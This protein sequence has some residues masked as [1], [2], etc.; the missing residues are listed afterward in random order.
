MKDSKNDLIIRYNHFCED[1]DYEKFLKRE[2]M[3]DGGIANKIHFSC[4]TP[5]RCIP[6]FEI[7]KKNIKIS[8]QCGYYNNTEFEFKNVILKFV[9]T[10]TP[11]I[12][13]DDYYRC[14]NEDHKNKKFKYYCKKCHQHLCKICLKRT[15][16]HSNHSLVIFDLEKNKIKN[17]A[18][19]INKKINELNDIDK[20]LKILFN[21]IYDNF[22][23]YPL[24]YSYICIFNE[25][26]RFLKDTF[27]LN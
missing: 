14:Q 24:N 12:N 11:F 22:Q 13:L 20:D 8:C 23:S 15:H 6:T 7:G 5:Y 16:V 1:C 10:I 3:Q 2:H 21:I 27:S 25:F 19:S 17:L 9:H 18:D 4:K 26:N